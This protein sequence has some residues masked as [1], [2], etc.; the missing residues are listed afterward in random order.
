MYASFT[1]EG[2]KFILAP[3]SK[4]EVS[5]IDPNVFAV[6]S[7]PLRRL[8]TDDDKVWNVFTCQSVAKREAVRS[9]KVEEDIAPGIREEDQ[10]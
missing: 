9:L 3:K 10:F 1:L 7:N 8:D 5:S 4:V 2:S 6:E